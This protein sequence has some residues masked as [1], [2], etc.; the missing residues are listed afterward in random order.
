MADDFLPDYEIKCH[1]DGFWASTSYDPNSSP[2]KITV[3]VSQKNKSDFHMFKPE[4]KIGAFKFFLKKSKYLRYKTK[5]D[6]DDI[7]FSYVDKKGKQRYITYYDERL[8]SKFY[9]NHDTVII[10]EQEEIK[11]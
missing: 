8:K 3:Y 7:E 6:K 10:S 4:D 5:T 2:D 9:K 11:K 1:F